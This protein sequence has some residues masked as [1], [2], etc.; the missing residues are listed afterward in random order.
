MSLLKRNTSTGV[1]FEDILKMKFHD[2][3]YHV[4]NN[5]SKTSCIVCQQESGENNRIIMK[6]PYTDVTGRTSKIDFYHQNEYG[7]K[8]YIEAKNQII[9]GSVDAKLKGYLYDIEKNVFN[10]E[11]FV[12]LFN[13]DWKGSPKILTYLEKE[14]PK[15]NGMMLKENQF[16]DLL[17]AFKMTS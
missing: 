5:K 3:G 7:K 2:N 8:F 9:T 14:M 12:F 4:T 1:K 11:T 6:L 13:N 10:G 16:E 15:L 17:K